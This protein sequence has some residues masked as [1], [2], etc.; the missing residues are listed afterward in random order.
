MQRPA[1]RGSR[2]TAGQLT[3]AATGVA[4]YST[5][6]MIAFG[7][8]LELSVPT[9][10]VLESLAFYRSLGFAEWPTGDIRRWH[11]AVV[12]DGQIAIGLHQ[13]GFEEPT[14]SFVR[15]ELARQVRVLESLGHTFEWQR[16]GDDDFH[17]AALRAVD[18][19]LIR[20]M[21]ARTFSPADAPDHSALGAPCA[22]VAL[23][24]AEPARTQTWLESAGFV[25]AGDDT[26]RLIAP[27]LRLGLRSGRAPEVAVLSFR[28]AAVST[29]VE[30]LA[31]RQFNP[32][33]GS[34]HYELRAP[35]GTRL[36]IEL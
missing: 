21:E 36:L 2:A 4:C 6:M 18:G 31:A 1:V 25:A 30:N 12:S 22:E 20:M 19:Q 3:E 5:P 8:F 7:R 13:A 16:L 35:E 10:N 23:Y 15:P 26:A 32:V 14:L 28:P 9:S 17:E 34:N 11:Y 33:R 29:V 24:C 27:G